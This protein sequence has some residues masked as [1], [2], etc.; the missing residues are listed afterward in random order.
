MAWQ[1][2]LEQARSIRLGRNTVIG[3]AAGIAVGLALGL[4]IGWVWW[5]VEWQGPATAAAPTPVAGSQFEAPEAKALY[6][7]AVADAFV[8]GTAAGDADAGAVAA[9]RLAA[10]GGDLRAAFNNSINFYSAQAGSAARVNNLTSLASALGIPLGDAAAATADP[11]AAG[12]AA[13]PAAAPSDATAAAAGDSGGSANWL[14][15]LL[16]ALALIVGGVYILWM[17]RQ[18]QSLGGDDAGFAQEEMSPAAAPSAMFERSSL[19]SP[20][21][22]SLTPAASVRSSIERPHTAP[23][24]GPHGFDDEDFDEFDESGD[25][26][27]GS[28]DETQDAI[29]A[30]I[31]SRLAAE[32]QAAARDQAADAE[33]D[34]DEWG[35]EED[36]EEE[37]DRHTAP[38]PG[39]VTSVGATPPYTGTHS[40]S[41]GEAS[42]A[43]AAST[44]PRNP[45][46]AT[47]QPPTPSRFAR[48]TPV[49]SYTATYYTGRADFDYTKNI[50][51]PNDGTYIGEYGIGI[52]AGQGLLQ[53]DMEKAIAIDV[54]LFDKSDERQLVSNKRSLLSLYADDHKRAEFER[55]KQSQPPIVAQ[56]STNFQLEGVQL[57]LDVLIKQ[58]EYTPEGYFQNVT[59]ELV[60]KRKS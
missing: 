16:T 7:G 47:L 43:P 50:Q 2:T 24:G 46:P 22:P 49:E 15:V 45:P 21:R 3:L 39:F 56:P 14:L 57:L 31:H 18:R 8:Y 4:L 13:L 33:D 38:P 25:A 26:D 48:Y 44:A 28:E 41:P 30:R 32:S 35:D 10:V 55:D 40:S 51:S 6:L 37:A 19:S 11:L 12:Q 52:P 53:N 34:A 5:P 60:L 9:Q 54:Y 23:A 27:Y 29:D 42:T 59:V 58:V 20:V 17:L 1:S 36:D